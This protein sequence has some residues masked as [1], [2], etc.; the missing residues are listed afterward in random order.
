MKPVHFVLEHPFERTLLTLN[1]GRFSSEQALRD[2]IGTSFYDEAGNTI[3]LS[4][5]SI[6]QIPVPDELSSLCMSAASG[7]NRDCLCVA[8]EQVR[9]ESK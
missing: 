4:D 1:P 2:S 5:C 6:K 3:L 7:H 9:K 8:C